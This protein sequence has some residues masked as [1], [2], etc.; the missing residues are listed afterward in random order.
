MRWW[1]LASRR[2]LGEPQRAHRGWV[3]ALAC[4]ELDGTPVAVTGGFGSLVH[5]WVCTRTLRSSLAMPDLWSLAV[6]PQGD[7]A[8]G[9]NRDVAVFSRRDTGAWR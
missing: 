8:A 3:N 9:L 7:I 4:V 2:P 6:T 5:I 1:D